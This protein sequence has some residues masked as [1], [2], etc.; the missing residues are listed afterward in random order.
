MNDFG[1]IG[2]L[3]KN[4][5]AICLIRQV[6]SFNGLDKQIDYQIEDEFPQ[7]IKKQLAFLK[8]SLKNNKTVGGKVLYTPKDSWGELLVKDNKVEKYDNDYG[9]IATAFV[10]PYPSD[11][12]IL[13]TELEKALKDIKENL[14]GL[15]GNIII[16]QRFGYSYS[17]AEW[18]KMEEVIKNTFND[19][20][21]IFF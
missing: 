13:L 15:E 5:N 2:K 12:F 21:I 3:F 10:N 11:L 6:D 19:R 9:F 7:A 8:K 18:K 14:T 4:N 16:P 20:E 17:D 1:M